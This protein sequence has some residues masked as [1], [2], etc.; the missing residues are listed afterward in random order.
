MAG[1]DLLEFHM[2]DYVDLG[3]LLTLLSN[4]TA[5][6]AWVAREALSS[7]QDAVVAN[8]SYIEQ[9]SGL[10]IYYPRQAYLSEYD[11]LAFSRDTRWDDFLRSLFD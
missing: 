7:L 5:D 11:H 9:A 3:H 4:E 1:F 2:P 6:A 8:G 10:S